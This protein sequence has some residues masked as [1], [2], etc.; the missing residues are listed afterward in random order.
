MPSTPPFCTLP[1]DPDGPTLYLLADMIA[2][3]T[4]AHLFYD[5]RGI[6]EVERLAE[7]DTLKAMFEEMMH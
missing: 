2:R 4:N 6:G 5:L 1:S 3:Y 7:V